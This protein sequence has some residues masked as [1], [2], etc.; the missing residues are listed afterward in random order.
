[1]AW[2]SSNT[3]TPS[4][5]RAQPID[6]LLHPRNPF[7][8]RVGPQRGVGGKKDAL[9]QPDRRALP[10]AR[11]RRDQQPLLA[12]RRPV[13]LGVLDQ[14]VGFARSRPRGGGPSASCRAGCRR[15]GGPFRRRC[16][17]RGT[18][19][20]G[21]GRHCSAS[22]GAAETTSKVSSTVHEPGE[23]SGMGLAGID[24]AFE[25]GVGEEASRDDIGRQM[26][27][28]GRL[29]R[30]DRGHGRRLHQSRRMRLRSGN[31]DRLKAVSFIKR[32][33]D[34]PVFGR[35]PVDS[36]VGELDACRVRAIAA[37]GCDAER[38]GQRSCSARRAAIGAFADAR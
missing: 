21:S 5:S 26:R 37:A 15:P 27:A 10:E 38:G 32:L 34:A 18:S 33:G 29:G 11:E 6:D 19:R 25:L 13:A 17:R 12:E 3:I 24:D 1:M 28:I 9:L 4:K 20:G 36:L 22:S 31:T 14:L 23:V 16:R 7:L 35:R 30:R 8:A 2:L